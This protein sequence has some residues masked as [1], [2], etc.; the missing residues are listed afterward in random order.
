MITNYTILIISYS[1]K[2][3]NTYYIYYILDN[4]YSLAKYEHCI[5]T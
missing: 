1:F 3:N 4:K 2:Y 5:D